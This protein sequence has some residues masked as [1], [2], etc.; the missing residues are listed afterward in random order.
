MVVY[1]PCNNLAPPIDSLP[2]HFPTR[3]CHFFTRIVYF[4]V[5]TWHL[6]DSPSTPYPPALSVRRQQRTDPPFTPTSRT[7]PYCTAVG[8]HHHR[9]PMH[10]VAMPKGLFRPVPIDRCPP[11]TEHERFLSPSDV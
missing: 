6:R 3:R 11:A 10:R 4:H 5:T 9:V 8:R 1:L 2:A 7:F